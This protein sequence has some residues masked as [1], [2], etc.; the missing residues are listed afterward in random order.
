MTDELPKPPGLFEFLD[1]VSETKKDLLV[2]PEF[3]RYYDPYMINVGL[4]QHLDGILFANVMNQ[5]PMVPKKQHFDFMIGVVPK[6]KR[7]GAWAK[8]LP[9]QKDELTVAKALGCSIRLARK[10]LKL[11]TAGQLIALEALVQEGGKT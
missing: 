3:V 7:R 4:S 2:D 11:L 6:R 1:A 9:K 8:K 10:H 5:F